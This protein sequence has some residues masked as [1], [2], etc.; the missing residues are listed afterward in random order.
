[1]RGADVPER[2]RPRAEL[3]ETRQRLR[4]AQR[5]LFD[6]RV[7]LSL[8]ARVCDAS[9]TRRAPVVL[10]GVVRAAVANVSPNSRVRRRHPASN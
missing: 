5:E 6:C 3:D 2:P 10:L 1:E 8:I 4:Q 9:R 7:R